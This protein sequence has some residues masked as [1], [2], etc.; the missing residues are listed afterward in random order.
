MTEIAQTPEFKRI[1]AVYL[2]MMLGAAACFISGGI[3]FLLGMIAVFAGI[4]IAYS[5]RKKTEDIVYKSHYDWQIRIFWIGNLIVFPVAM[6]INAVLI[7][8]FTD[9]AGL[10]TSAMSGSYGMDI[11]R[12]ESDMVAFQQENMVEMMIIKWATYGLAL[13]WWIERY[14]KGYRLFQKHTIVPETKA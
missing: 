1:R 12:M 7:Y 13:V 3:V 5:Y 8:Y 2:L 10:I 6:I 11:A 9:F 14:A 4:V